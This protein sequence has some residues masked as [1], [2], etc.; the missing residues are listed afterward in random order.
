M[1]ITI[2]IEIIIKILSN[3]NKIIIKILLSNYYHG[4]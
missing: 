2:I 1:I 3:Y 4:K